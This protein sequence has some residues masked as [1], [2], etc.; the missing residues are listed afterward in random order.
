MKTHKELTSWLRCY[1]CGYCTPKPE[2]M[3]NREVFVKMNQKK[4][5]YISVQEYLGDVEAASLTSELMG[6][7]NTLIPLVNEVLEL[8]GESRRVTSGYRS[9]EKHWKIYEGINK[10]RKAQRLPELKVPMTSAH[11]S[12][13]AVDLEDSDGRLDQWCVDNIDLLTSKGLY[14]EHPDDTKGWCHLQARK[15][16]SGNNPFKP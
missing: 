9:M 15:P 14:I 10:R 1:S 12:C 8:F 11:L 2:D 5:V 13:L 7:V 16:K 4:T 6:N 3:V